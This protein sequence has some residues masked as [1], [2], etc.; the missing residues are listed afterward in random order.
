MNDRDATNDQYTTAVGNNRATGRLANAPKP[1]PTT[2]LRIYSLGPTHSLSVDN[3]TYTM[4]HP[5]LISNTGNLGD[6]EGFSMAGPT[7]AG[8]TAAL[9]YGNPQFATGPTIELNDAD[10]MTLSYLTIDAGLHGLWVRNGSDNF[11]GHHLSISN[12]TQD[13]LRFEPTT[14]GS[15]LDFIT[16]TANGGYGIYVSGPLNRLADSESGFNQNTG[17]HLISPGPVQLEANS[18]HDNLG[19]GIY[20]QQSDPTAITVGNANLNLSRGNMVRDNAARGIDARGN[21][22]VAGN[23]VNGHRSVISAGISLDF[24]TAQQNV[25]W[26]NYLGIQGGSLT[27]GNRVYK[28][29]TTGIY[30]VGG[31][32]KENVVYSNA[33]G[34]DV[35]GNS[36]LSNNLV[37]GNSQVGVNLRVPT[38]LVNNTVYQTA[39]NAITV[40]SQVSNVQLRNNVFWTSNGYGVFVPTSSQTGFQSDYNLIYAVANG[41]IGQWQGVDRVT[42]AD[43][44]SATSG[45]QNSLAQD[46]FFVDADGA[47]NLLGFVSTTND[48]R[49]DDFHE[50]SLFGSLHGGSLAPVISVGGMGVIAGLPSLPTGTPTNDPNQSVVIDRGFGLDPFGNELSPNGGFINLGV[51]GNTGQSS[52]SPTQ[53]VTVT[54]PDG[55]EL[56]PAG[57]NFAIRWRSH[58]MAGNVKLELLDT[59]NTVHSTIAATTPNDGDFAWA[60]PTGITAGNYKVRVTR[61][62][63][64]MFADASNSLFTI[65]PPVNVFY[66]NDA[67][68]NST[69]DWTT[70]P[71]NDANDGLSPA[72]PKASLRALLDAYTFGPNDTIRVDTGTYTATTNILVAADDSGVR[73]EGYHNAAFPTRQAILNRDSVSSGS[74]GIQFTGAD[75]VTIDHLVITG[76][77]YGVVALAGAD[78]D[79]IRITSNTIQGNRLGGIYIDASNEAAQ[80]IGSEVYNHITAGIQIL[81]SSGAVVRDN[82]VHDMLGGTGIE[83]RGLPGSS[84]ANLVTG[85]DSYNN[86]YDFIAFSAAGSAPVTVENNV[87]HSGRFFG[88]QANGG[89]V[90]V[91]NNRVF[92]NVGFSTS[93]GIDVAAGATARDNLVYDNVIGIAA[94]SATVKN[95]RVFHNNDAGIVESSATI[96][97]NVVYSNPV[98]IRS[99]TGL[100]TSNLVYANTIDGIRIQQGGSSGRIIGNTV[101]QPVGNALRVGG[102]GFNASNVT[103]RNNIFSVATGYAVHVDPASQIGFNSNYNALVTTGTGKLGRWANQDFISLDD[104]SL[105]LGLDQNSQTADPQFIDVDGADNQLG[106]VGTTDFGLDDDFRVVTGSPTIDAG[107]PS[108]AFANE[109]AANGGRV[110]LGHTGNTTLATTSAAQLVQVLSPNG[111]EKLERGQVIPI[112]WRTSGITGG[113]VNIDL[114]AGNSPASILSIATATP[115]D[116]GESWT[117]PTTLA[118]GSYRVQVRSNQGIQPSDTSNIPFQ[119]VNNGQHFYVNDSSTANDVFTTAMGSNS[120]S[121]KSPSQPLAS[122]TALLAAYDLDPGDVIHVDAGTYMLT[123]NVVIGSQDSGVR[124]EGPSVGMGFQP[125]VALNR[126][127]TS[128]GSYGI[129]LAG[130]DDVT[131]DYLAITGG[132]YG[133]VALSGVDSDRLSI[134]HSKIH[135]NLRQGIYIS[136]TNDIL[137][138]ADN[139]VYN[140]PSGG[141]YVE[142]AGGATIN[143]NLVYNSASGRGIELSSPS[144]AVASG[145]E[146]YGSATGIFAANSS[147]GAVTVSN[148]LVYD[149]RNFGIEGGTNVQVI[150]NTVFGT[151]TGTGSGS[152]APLGIRITTG[153][154]ARDNVVFDNIRGIQAF[155]ATAIN[156]RVYHNDLV[157]I[158]GDFAARVEGNTVYSNGVGIWGNSFTGRIANNLVYAN[159]NDGIW[160]GSGT[161]GRVEGNTIYQDGTGDAVQVGGGHPEFFVTTFPVSN[162]FFANNIFHVAQ[163]YALNVAPDSGTG[164]T[165]D[166]NDYSLSGTGKL[167]RWEDHDFTSR[168]DWFF[169]LGMDAHS[170][171]VDP[172]F[173][174]IDGPDNILGYDTG[175]SIDRGL[176]DNF[177]VMPGSPTIDAGDPRSSFAGETA[178]N[179]GRLNLGHTGDTLQAQNSPSQSVQVVSPNGLEKFE[180]GQQVR[181][182]WQTA[183]ITNLAAVALIDAG[184]A[185]GSGWIADKYKV[186]GQTFS[187][188]NPVNLSGVTNPAPA[189]TYQVGT[190]GGAGA[191]NRVAYQLPVGDGSYTIRL[192]FVEPSLTGPGQRPF[193]I[194][195]N[196]VTVQTGFDIFTA[197]GGQL[198]ATTLSFSTT[199]SG[200]QGISLEMVNTLNGFGAFVTGIEL[201]AVNPAGLANPTVNLELSTNNGVIWNTI[202]ANVGMDRYGRGSYVWTPTAETVGNSA[203]IRVT[204]NVGS[205]SADQ[206][207]SAF[208]IASSGHDYYVNDGS[209]ANDV[210]TTVEGDNL[211]S[212]KR[213]NEP[214][215]SLAA[216]LA[217]YDLD[218]NDVIHVDRGTY[219]LYRN[220]AINVQ[221]S[222][223][224]IEGPSFAATTLPPVAILNRGNT[225]PGNYTVEMAGA[226]DVTIDR[227]AI[228]GGTIGV[229]AANSFQSDRWTLSN[230]DLY[231]SFI[232]LGGALAY[233]VYIG[234]GNDD[235]RILGNRAFNNVSQG[236]LGIGIYV[237]GLRTLVE[238]NE[239]FGQSYGIDVESNGSA[240]T[241]NW[242]TVRG[243]VVHDNTVAG[244]YAI[245]NGLVTNNTAFNQSGANAVGIHVILAAAADNVA[246]N[247][248]IGIISDR[249]TTSHNRIYRNTVGIAGRMNGLIENN[250]VYSNSI[251]ISGDAAAG[252]FG[253]IV[254]NLVYGN[255]SQGIFIQSSFNTGLRIV[256]NTVYQSVGDAIRIENTS[257]GTTLRNNVVSVDAGYAIYVAPNSQASFS[258]NYNLLRKGVDPN[259]H[260]GFWGGAIRDTLASWQ[261][262]TGQ[263]AN[264]LSVDPQWV[265]F[266]GPDNV[267]GYTTAGGGYDG[268]RDDNFHLH[269]GSPAIDRADS[270]LA[271]VLDRDGFGR[272]DDPGTANLGIPAGL[273]YVDL[274]AYEF[275]GSSNDVTPPTVVGSSVQSLGTTG[276]LVHQVQ[277]TFSEPLDALDALAI[278]HYELRAA[279]PN[280]LFGDSDDTVFSL[281]PQYTSGSTNITL[282]VANGGATVP[283]GLHRLTVRGSLHDRAGNALDG[284]QNGTPGGDYVRTNS[285]PTL[286]AIANQTIPEL[287]PFNFTAAASDDGPVMYSLASGA[288]TGASIHPTSGMFTW[289][290]T[291]AQGPGVFTVTVIAT[292]TGTPTM[293]DLRTFT[294]TV[295]EVNAPPVINPIADQAVVRGQLL[296]FVVTATDPDIPVNTWVFSLAAGA[297]T[298]A[299]IHPI[300]GVFSWT[301]AANQAQG[302]YDITVLAGDNGSPA[303]FGSRTFRVTVYPINP[304]L[305]DF[306]GDGFLN[307]VDIDAL[308]GQIAAG[309]NATSFDLNGDGLVNLT[310]RD[311]WLSVAGA[312]NLP[313]GN[314]YRFGDANLDGVVDGSDF[315]LWNANKFTA[316]AKWSKGDFNADGFVDGSDFNIWNANKFTSAAGL[317]PTTV[318]P[319]RSA[320]TEITNRIRT[321]LIDDLFGSQW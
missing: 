191:G 7:T 25:V 161:G 141:I 75:N 177:R 61:L 91:V 313:S 218:P 152:G 34:I 167:G 273:A 48:G 295:T 59:N 258:S 216:L 121:G 69:G 194:R 35:A 136:D 1:L 129:Q 168:T 286:A 106:F 83:V 171:A 187:F 264:S 311:R 299:S 279:G 317:R 65:P 151:Q 284:D 163:G 66:V 226:D 29:T 287:L 12:A 92:G 169:E 11:V 265:D 13:G 156:N 146:V 233:G 143:N 21:V 268:G 130:A 309:T 37:Y 159:A 93:T 30:A 87:A 76:G 220:L 225:L 274:G 142:Y 137:L 321:K 90:L 316:Q 249:S 14:S 200:N 238:N 158:S 120:N 162:A 43:W 307:S 192:H 193:D 188:A 81:S 105:E 172:Q 223:V 259:A 42:L 248:T 182:D 122:L 154:V 266:D 128:P 111:L 119:I 126:A 207:D 297:P 176:D 237:S 201:T 23:T 127:N 153:S 4:F 2:L 219:R 150:G 89:N 5:L 70:A 58:D 270:A 114:I 73:I 250:H 214:M 190:Y 242:I 272:V 278:G 82:V 277:V 210:F 298:G 275:Q 57:Q 239:A 102:F 227:L 79:G 85:N 19:S 95:N 47:D 148:N 222:G 74:Y 261:A 244:V 288:P 113:T 60:I 296:S 301:P 123:Q 55:G 132:E 116:G 44:Q 197:A 32:A 314:A 263:D 289:T 27:R 300:T 71:G 22:L 213:P 144:N 319:T 294:I 224:R 315:N 180:V 94:S 229:Y 198:K 88:I 234:Q 269:G 134:T 199:A 276:N 135:T 72:T 215:A 174:D 98:G 86:T 253:Q 110:N 108:Y 179:G 183:G 260:V 292:D 196:G 97:G 175:T 206:S 125:V 118:E 235:V 209:T 318:T 236:Q 147:T 164:F 84:I 101:Y 100:T 228:T 256:N 291:E 64:G 281:T 255:T 46:P 254:S 107:D 36:T 68:V 67:T 40:G 312:V 133:I 28:N 203:L 109:P 208:L 15:T 124:I 50:Q 306:N 20:L 56:W 115:N 31:T 252:F 262:A 243:N 308:V 63:A 157:G 78:S 80:V 99:S 160:L 310:D 77:E 303:L 293:N 202:A 53:Y 230:N 149:N 285:R 173:I 54:R 217:A 112:S 165:S 240:S 178:P 39:G 282:V 138:V 38:T 24:G 52:F 283:G 186:A 26:D 247:N 267:L 10:F 6:D 241:A 18:V 103:V 204:P 304:T 62:D 290:P 8:R 185:G 205:V 104:W 140:N 232:N 16:A 96:D 211:A 45:D 246:Y 49:D 17:I 131:L 195:L 3:G 271:P 41:R 231:G 251:G 184:G 320:E 189:A 139:E 170:I 33:V 257:L 305:A 51:Y 117:I 221:D 166:H 155:D 245:N 145:N 212:G 280:G 181:I 9:R 302:H